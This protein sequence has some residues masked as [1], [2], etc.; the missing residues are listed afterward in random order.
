MDVNIKRAVKLF[1]S[2][3]SFEMIYFEAF[4]NALDAGATEFNIFITLPEASDWPNMVLRLT[5][6]GEGFTDERFGKFKKLLDVE[7]RTHK[8]LGRLVYL[9]YF[10]NVRVESV[11]EPGKVRM[12]EFNEDFVGSNT[13]K[14]TSHQETGTN[15]FFEGFNNEKIG[16]TDYLK[17]AY[18]KK[19]LLENFYLK[20][21]RAKLVGKH[22]VVNI[23]LKVGGASS[24]ETIN[25]SALPDFHE[26]QLDARLDL[27]N[28]ITLY[29]YI[30]T[31]GNSADRQVVTALAVDDRTHKVSIIADENMPCGYEMVFLLMSETFQGGIDGARQNLT[32]EEPTLNQVKII[33]RDAIA[34]VVKEAFPQIAE[35]NNKRKAHLETLYPHLCG[36]FD[37]KEIGYSSQTDVLKKAQE[38]YFRDQKEILGATRLTDEQ[39]E[40]A[41][42]LSARS[43]AEYI[44]FRQNVIKKMKSFNG[45]EVEADLHNLIAPKGAEF[46]EGELMKDLYRNNVWVL[47][48]KFMSYCTVL[49]E[50]EMSKVI[51]SLTE[52]EPKNDDNDRPDIVMFFSSDPTKEGNMVD[53]VVVELKR[54]GI[55]AEHNSIVEFQ[56]DT[57]T[58]RLAEYYHKR[59][60]RMWFY[61]V[62]DFDER[63]ETHLI[64][65]DFN[66]L[67]SNGN[68]YFRSKM[69]YTDKTKTFGVIQNAYILDF[70]AL[71]ED[72]NSRNETFLKILQSNFKND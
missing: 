20:F 64:N 23:T 24:T 39:Y 63:Y 13:I 1:F 31:I 18:I 60:Q 57:R 15:L 17:P 48:D 72:A 16:K 56:L 66:P 42:T 68:V 71:V 62:V 38:K 35:T 44:L 55:K 26:K 34:E 14:D 46:H 59:I 33:F 29:Y 36:Y 30:N 70:K 32:I 47:D 7:E 4:A 51:A 50:A 49:S 45:E 28:S 6:N 54:L 69:V 19:A 5:D 58:Q 43:L 8:G 65:N 40:K 11:F 22:I 41:L 2:K 61:G 25:S 21:Y 37:D 52:G 67:Y 12:F 9:C 27:L 3:S 53:V 10:D